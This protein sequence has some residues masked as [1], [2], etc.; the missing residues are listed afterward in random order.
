[1]KTR[2]IF[3]KTGFFE[4]GICTM[5]QIKQELVS[6]MNNE[7][8]IVKCIQDLVKVTISNR[9]MYT[10]IRACFPVVVGKMSVVRGGIV[11]RG[12]ALLR[13]TTC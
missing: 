4:R 10:Y 12:A 2:N 8:K 7:T 3:E 5:F 13:I 11:A 9:K 1:M 6:V